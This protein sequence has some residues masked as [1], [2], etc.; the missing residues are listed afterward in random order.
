MQGTKFFILGP[1][2]LQQNISREIDIL[3]SAFALPYMD[4]VQLTVYD[5]DTAENAAF[6]AYVES[7]IPPTN[8]IFPLLFLE[9]DEGV[10]Q[11]MTLRVDNLT[12][13]LQEAGSHLSLSVIA[14]DSVRNKRLVRSISSTLDPMQDIGRHLKH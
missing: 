5:G 7:G 3:P 6:V 11:T 13:L 8:S 10:N 4:L 2:F 9:P 12:G 1:R 14:V